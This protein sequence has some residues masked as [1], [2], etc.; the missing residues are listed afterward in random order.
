MDRLRVESHLRAC[1]EQLVMG[2]SGEAEGG[3]CQAPRPSMRDSQGSAQSLGQYVYLG[4]LPDYITGHTQALHEGACSHKS[5]GGPEA[6]LPRGIPKR[7]QGLCLLAQAVQ[8]VVGQQQLGV[9]LLEETFQQPGP[10]LGQCLLQVQVGAAVVQAQL[11]IQVPEG[12]G[13]LRVQ[14]PKGPGEGILQC[15]LRVIQQALEMVCAQRRGI[16]P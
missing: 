14:V 7:P 11:G 15:A 2:W 10:E 3:G 13:V 16:T 4:H 1:C 8:V 12:P 6:Q 9:Q 5:T